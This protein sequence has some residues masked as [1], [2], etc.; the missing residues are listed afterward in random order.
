M[1]ILDT[2]HGRDV[3]ILQH[4]AVPEQDVVGTEGMTVRPANAAPQMEGE[5]APAILDVPVRGQVRKNLLAHRI[6]AYETVIG[7][8]GLDDTDVAGAG[9]ITTPGTAI[10]A[11]LVRRCDDEGIVRQAFG[12]R[13]QFAGGRLLRPLRRLLES[14]SGVSLPFA[15]GVQDLCLSWMPLGG[16]HRIQRGQIHRSGS[17]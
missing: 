7:Q 4:V 2:D 6:P 17:R 5:A 8:T 9:G 15:D 14:R 11:H 13:R 1:A 3:G 16:L 10:G 12:H